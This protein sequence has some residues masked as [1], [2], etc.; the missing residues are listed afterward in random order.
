VD[1]PIRFASPKALRGALTLPGDKSIS[2]RALLFAA[3]APGTT[4][5]VGLGTGED[6]RS[7]AKALQQLG[8]SLTWQGSDATVQGRPLAQWHSPAAPIDCGNSGTTM[9]LLTGLLAAAPG[10]DATLT[11]DASLLRRPMARLA[12]PLRRM[13]AEIA[14]TADGTGP[15]RV[16]GKSLHGQ[17]YVLQVASAQVKT[18]LL[19]AG[20]HASGATTVREPAPSRDHSERMLGAMGADL[21]VAQD[22]VRIRPGALRSAGRVH[23]PGDPSS[24]AFFAIAVLLHP[25][26]DVTIDGVCLNP[27][28]TGFVSV[29][30]RMGARL[31]T[32]VQR[33]V[34]GEP[35][36]RLHA[37]SSVLRATRIDAS[38]VP[39]CID[40]LPILALAAACARGTSVFSGIGELRFK[41][42]DRLE[43]TARLLRLLHV[44]VRDS[45]DR[46]EIVGKGQ[47]SRLTGCAFTA[48]ADH[49]MAMTAAIAG[50][51]GG[52]A[53]EVEGVA[54]IASSFPGFEDALRRLSS[55]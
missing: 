45:S 15:V 24:A 22:V 54:S 35:V 19:L 28:R 52:G 5:L 18:A 23:V 46:L 41:E 16:L 53:V 36:G 30:E 51:V 6:V 37:L 44:D 26:G 39:A 29:L 49:R 43:A 27:T 2:H 33:T 1:R 11:G 42:S 14:L 21:D 4:E 50:A 8:I 20:L 12:E 48:G 47:A 13:G 55:F 3:L 10:M 40:E 31:L 32:G 7:T 34:L 25:R 38:E 17:Q 9:R